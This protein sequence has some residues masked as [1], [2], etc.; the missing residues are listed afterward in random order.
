MVYIFVVLLEPTV[1]LVSVEV[2][3]FFGFNVPLTT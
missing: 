2:G 1:G 3:W